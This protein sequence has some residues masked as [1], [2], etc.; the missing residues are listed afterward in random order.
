MSTRKTVYIDPMLIIKEK[1]RAESHVKKARL[2]GLEE[3]YCKD[4][5]SK[6]PIV[7][8]DITPNRNRTKWKP[9]LVC[10]PCVRKRR[11]NPDNKPKGSYRSNENVRKWVKNSSTR[12]SELISDS[13]IRRLYNKFGYKA[14]DVT[15]EMIIKK[16]EEVIARR[17]SA[18]AN[19]T[20]RKIKDGTYGRE[21]RD[22]MTDGYIRGLIKATTWYQ[23]EEVTD[24]MIQEYRANL[25]LKRAER[26]RKARLTVEKIEPY[27]FFV[28]KELRD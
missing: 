14:K 8:F 23:G 1:R 6:K 27:Q 19:T 2:T 9:R 18:A 21:E 13:Y 26:N 11:T 5:Q 3:A 10:N 22:K 28:P 15:Q 7:D 17:A 4:C 12:A 16:R 20:E 25:I 24:Q